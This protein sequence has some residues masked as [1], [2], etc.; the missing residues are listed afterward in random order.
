VPTFDQNLLADILSSAN[1]CSSELSALKMA[2]MMQRRTVKG[3]SLTGIASY[4]P[5]QNERCGI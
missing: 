5:A 2:A 1:F 4:F 3:A